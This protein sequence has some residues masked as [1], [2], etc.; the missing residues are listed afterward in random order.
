MDLYLHT[1]KRYCFIFA[2]FNGSLFTFQCTFQWIFIYTQT[3]DA[4]L[5]YFF[6][7][8]LQC[9]PHSLADVVDSDWNRP[10]P[11]EMGAFPYVSTVT[12]E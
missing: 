7:A 3:K 8:L 10:Y 2:L 11:R 5:F 9:A 4:I 1:N 6:F 12:I